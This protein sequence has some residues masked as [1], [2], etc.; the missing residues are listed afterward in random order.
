LAWAHFLVVAPDRKIFVAE[1]LN[2]RCQVFAPTA[3]SGRMADYVPAKRQFFTT[4]P[5]QPKPADTKR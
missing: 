1:I 3:A 4:V 2:W 5:L